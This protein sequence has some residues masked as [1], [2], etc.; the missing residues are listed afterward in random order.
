MGTPTPTSMPTQTQ[1]SSCVFR[2]MIEL[3]L[4]A[5][6][7]NAGADAACP[8][9]PQVMEMVPAG[10]DWVSVSFVQSDPDP[11]VSPDVGPLLM[12]R[13]LALKLSLR[14]VIT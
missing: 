8:L 3:H 11:D 4:D 9:S 12:P 14:L 1:A 5:V 2:L 7:R 10:S 6:M 13:I